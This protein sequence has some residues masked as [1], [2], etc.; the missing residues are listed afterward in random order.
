MV[1]AIDSSTVWYKRPIRGARAEALWQSAF[2]FNSLL[3]LV[4]VPVSIEYLTDREF[5]KKYLPMFYRR[6]A[7]K[8]D[9]H[10]FKKMV[11]E[12]LQKNRALKE[13]QS[14]SSIKTL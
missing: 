11:D 8:L 1:L 14:N 13:M 2:A 4:V 9:K 3:I 7:I 6:R 10:D 12:G 5:K